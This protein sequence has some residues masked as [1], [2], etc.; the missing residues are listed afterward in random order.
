M[1]R[2][3]GSQLFP[4]R[5]RK[6][7]YDDIEIG[8]DFDKEKGLADSGDFDHDLTELL[9]TIGEAAKER[10]TALVIFIDESD[11]K[12]AIQK[13]ARDE[14]VEVSSEALDEIIKQTQ[15]YPYFLQEWGKHSWDVANCSPIEISDVKKATVFALADLDAS[16]FRVRFDRCQE[17]TCPPF[18][19]IS[20][21]LF[22]ILRIGFNL[23]D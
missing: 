3:V 16:F 2:L 19:D 15:C 6:V 21:R 12:D 23:K 17:C 18:S 7:K 20:N 1:Q 14:G 8:V 9:F 4:L 22:S 10:N 5:L 11:A 13:P